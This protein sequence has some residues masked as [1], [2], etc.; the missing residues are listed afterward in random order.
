[1]T[2]AVGAPDGI[3]NEGAVKLLRTACVTAG[4]YKEWAE[5]RGVKTTSISMILSGTRR[6][7]P[8][9]SLALELRREWRFFPLRRRSMSDAA[10]I[11]AQAKV[12]ALTKQLA[13]VTAERD[14]MKA[15]RA[16]K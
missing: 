15:E 4:G 8:Q 7:T 1:M 6:M 12:A 13:D 14:K 10:A 3:D 16:A 5:P 9:V 2:K 11:T